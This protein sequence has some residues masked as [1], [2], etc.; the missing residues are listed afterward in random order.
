MLFQV[1]WIISYLQMEASLR[2]NQDVQVSLRCID[3]NILTIRLWF[4]DG[5]ELVQYQRSFSSEELKNIEVSDVMLVD[6]V[7]DGFK[8]EIEKWK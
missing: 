1:L 4:I 8:V 5:D 6:L 7:L 3:K 2:F